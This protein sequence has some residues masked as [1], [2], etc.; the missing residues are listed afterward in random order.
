MLK[1]GAEK[2]VLDVLQRFI[3]VAARIETVENRIGSV[4]SGKRLRIV[5][6]GNIG[7]NG[8]DGMSKI[9]RCRTSYWDHCS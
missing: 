5:L 2:F 8:A 9:V 6:F 7:I 3:V 1:Q 4:E